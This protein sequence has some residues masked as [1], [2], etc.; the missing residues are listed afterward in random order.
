MS[1]KKTNTF[2]FANMTARKKKAFSKALGDCLQYVEDHFEL[3]CDVCGKS[4]PT[5]D[6]IADTS[7]NYPQACAKCWETWEETQRQPGA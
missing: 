3:I 4:T 1:K 5:L 6:T 7:R 2:A